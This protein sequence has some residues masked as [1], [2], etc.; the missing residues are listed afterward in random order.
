MKLKIGI[1]GGT[2]FIGQ[3][4]IE[5]FGKQHDLIVA[6]A[7]EDVEKYNSLAHYN[8]IFYCVS[9]FEN[10]FHGC[11]AVIHLGGKVMNGFDPSME[12]G[13]YSENLEVC[14]NL[15]RACKNIGVKNV[16]FT[17]SV[18]V[19]DQ[20]KVRVAKEESVCQP[21]TIYGVMKLA[22]ENIAEIY[23]RRYAM[24]IKILRIA[25]VLGI[26]QKLYPE[27]FWDKL[28]IESWNHHVIPVYG[29][30]LTGRDIIYVKDAAEALMAAAERPELSGIYNIG[31]GHIATN[32]EIAQ[33]FCKVFENPQ[34]IYL[35][36]SKKETGIQ[37]C[38]N[39][40]KAKR[41]LHFNAK[42]DIE[43][44]VRDMKLEYEKRFI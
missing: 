42:Y 21:N 35:D 12:V 4:F 44:L 19:Y 25:Q 13:S 39:C 3:Y 26:R 23:N 34:G 14:E 16:V 1:T 43:A 11:D 9:D 24:N 29:K 20:M 17:S 32:L 38:M 15:F 28:V 37:T 5:M 22:A 6:T 27:Q 33:V 41:D 30:G 2:G 7:Q 36:N 8:K 18:A 10:I 40:E 31:T